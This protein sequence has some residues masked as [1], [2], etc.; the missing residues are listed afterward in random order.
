MVLFPDADPGEAI[1]SSDKWNCNKLR[2]LN[3][4]ITIREENG[5]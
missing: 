2:T 5:K 1:T 3:N 4:G